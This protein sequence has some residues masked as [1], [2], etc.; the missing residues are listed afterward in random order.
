MTVDQF[1]TWI[2]KVYMTIGEPNWQISL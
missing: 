1:R 2:S